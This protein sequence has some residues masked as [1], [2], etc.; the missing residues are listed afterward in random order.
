MHGFSFM[1]DFYFVN[2]LGTPCIL[3][4]YLTNKKHK[5][6]STPGT[7]IKTTVLTAE[8]KQIVPEQEKKCI[9]E[10]GKLYMF[11]N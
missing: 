9:T 3:C 8:G 1:S 4:S 2:L 6:F 5:P 10:M 7:T 11:T